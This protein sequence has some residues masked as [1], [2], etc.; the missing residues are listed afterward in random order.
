MN[1]SYLEGYGTACVLQSLKIV[2]T[3]D[4][5]ANLGY[6]DSPFKLAFIPE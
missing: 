2:E 5:S 1:I 3:S 6:K 4:H